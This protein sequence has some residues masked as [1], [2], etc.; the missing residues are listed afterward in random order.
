MMGRGVRYPRATIQDTLRKNFLT[1]HILS[2]RQN[3]RVTV[4]KEYDCVQLQR[5]KVFGM[6]RWVDN[7][8]LTRLS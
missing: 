1:H 6:A 3:D 5:G 8:P 4:D 2:V 7:T